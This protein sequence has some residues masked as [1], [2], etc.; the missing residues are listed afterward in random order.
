MTERTAIDLPHAGISRPVTLI[1]PSGKTPSGGRPLVVF[2]PG[3]GGTAAWADADTNWSAVAERERFVL[4][5]PEGLPLDPRKQ[6][7]FLTNPPRWNDG[8]T[9]PGDRLHTEA[10]DVGFL[11]RLVEELAEDRQRVFVTGFSN[12]AGMAFRFAAE[13]ADLVTAVAPVA[14]Y[15]WT[16]SRPTRT[17]PTLYLVGDTDPLIPLAGGPV[18]LPWGGSSVM[19][20]TVADTLTRWE[21][22]NGQPARFV[23]VPGLGHHWPGGKGLLGEKWGGPVGGP[24]DGTAAVWDFFREAGR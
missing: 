2:L 16:D 9:R 20:P 14:G 19:R 13:R 4:A 23:L 1:R 10:D 12:G 8:S 7:K 22:L 18:R 5:L 15:C 3:T 21:Q 11:A 6:P 24:M 17:V